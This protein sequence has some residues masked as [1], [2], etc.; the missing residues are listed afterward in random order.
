MFMECS[1]LRYINMAL[2][3]NKL[4]ETFDGIPSSGTIATNDNLKAEISNE[5]QGWKIKID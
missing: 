1:N 2:L 4:M 3:N 5:L